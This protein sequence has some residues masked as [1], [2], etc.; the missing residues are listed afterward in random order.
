MRRARLNFIAPM[1][2]AL[3]IALSA[4]GTVEQTT[5]Y[6]PLTNQNTPTGKNA[7]D[8]SPAKFTPDLVTP[9]GFKVKTNGQYKTDAEKKAAAAAIDRYWSEVSKCASGA[10]NAPGADNPSQL[11]AE[12]PT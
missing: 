11:I 7:L 9:A 4:C 10:V 5:T 2:L 8:V 3:S 6:Y 1:A 12:F